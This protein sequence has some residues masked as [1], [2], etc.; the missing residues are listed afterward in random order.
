M[1]VA[2][3][4]NQSYLEESL[5]QVAKQLSPEVTRVTYRLRPDSTDEP[6]VFFRVLLAD[7]YIKEETLADLTR[8]IS[9]RILDAVRPVENWGLRSYFNF[10]SV[11]E[12]ARRRD[13]DW[14]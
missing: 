13:P 8:R 3:G 2:A 14:E 6:S 11:S 5:S 7:E 9:D 1:H 10:R 12:Q 4:I